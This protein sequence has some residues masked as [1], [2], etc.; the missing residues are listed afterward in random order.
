MLLSPTDSAEIALR[1]EGLSKEFRFYPHPWQR[2]L[3]WLSGGYIKRSQVFHALRDITFEVTRGSALGIVGVNGAGK[4]TLLKIICGTLYPTAG[5]VAVSGRVASLLELGTGFHPDF[6]G[7]QN[8]LFNARFL[9]LSDEEI[10][11]RMEDI[12]AFS[13][14]EAFIDRPLRTYSSGMVLRLAFSVMANV[15]PQ[16][17]IIDEALSV[18]DAYFQQKCIQRIR[19]F[20]EQ[21][22][23]LLFVSHDPG[24]VKTLCTQALLLHHGELLDTGRPDDVLASYNTLIARQVGNREIF[25]LEAGRQKTTLETPAGAHPGDPGD[26]DNL[27][28]RRSGSFQAIVEDVQIIDQHNQEGRNFIA[29]EQIGIHVRARCLD[30]VDEPTIGILIRDRLGNDV[31]GTNTYLQQLHVGECRTGDIIEAHFQ[32]PLNLG[33]GEYNLTVAVHTLDVHM[34]ECFDWV[35]RALVFKVLPPVSGQFIGTSFLQPEVMYQRVPSGGLASKQQGDSVGWEQA[36]TAAFG[37]EF[38]R[39]L[40]V[41]ESQKPWLLSGWY[42]PEIENGIGFR[43]TEEH[44]S[45]L[46]DLRGETLSFEMY[47]DQPAGEQVSDSETA[48]VSKVSKTNML[49]AWV[50]DQ[51]LGIVELKRNGEWNVCSVPIP[52]ALR[53]AH[54]FVRMHMPG[55]SP[56]G[57]GI[58]DD[59]RRLGIRLQ[60]IWVAG[61]QPSR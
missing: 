28:P 42:P 10:Q 27:A 35:D 54:G 47:I 31:Y 34:H 59:T 16:L 23:T 38:P 32:M 55:W 22:V 17:L 39:T 53:V 40:C 25:A 19:Q 20:R 52:L 3:E 44:V 4:S 8:I 45:F 61:E 18:G 49:E 5:Q 37:T 56:A 46:I 26:Q 21:G 33:P 41:A 50:F 15:D 14:L 11:D 60:R 12:L 43:W 1:V 13:E 9:G 48:E 51:P 24:A 30:A 58:S 2:L 57:L 29:G 6:T 7:R 36:L